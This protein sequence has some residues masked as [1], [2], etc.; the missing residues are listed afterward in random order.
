MLLLELLQ[1]TAGQGARQVLLIT[2][3]MG[4]KSRLLHDLIVADLEATLELSPDIVAESSIK[5][6]MLAFGAFGRGVVWFF[7]FQVLISMS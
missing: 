2:A 1:P 5:V 7:P 4:K 6:R 3:A